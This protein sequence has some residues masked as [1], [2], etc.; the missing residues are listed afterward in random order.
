MDKSVP[1]YHRWPRTWGNWK[2]G[3]IV[4]CEGDNCPYCKARFQLVDNETLQDVY[5][6]TWPP[7][8][9]AS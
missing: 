5:E 7:P 3:A 6:A 4:Q 8:C 1:P 9:A 2:A